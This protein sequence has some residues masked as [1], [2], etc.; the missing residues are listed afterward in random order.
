L[1]ADQ[2]LVAGYCRAFGPES[3]PVVDIDIG[4]AVAFSTPTTLAIRNARI[5]LLDSCGGGEHDADRTA[6][7]SALVNTEHRLQALVYLR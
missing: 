7:G 6:Y 3:T 2:L 5:R 1:G 4:V